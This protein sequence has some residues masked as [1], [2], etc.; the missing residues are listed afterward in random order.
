MNETV[1][2]IKDEGYASLENP[3]IEMYNQEA[4]DILLFAGT[5]SSPDSNSEHP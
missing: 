2:K 1:Q 3:G 5:K 4:R